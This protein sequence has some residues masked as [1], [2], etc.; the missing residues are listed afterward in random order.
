MMCDIMIAGDEAKFGQPEITL[1]TIPGCGGTQRLVRAIGKSKAMHLCLTGEMIDAEEALNSGLVAKVVP[2]E[3]LMDEAIQMGEK[4][5]SF[6]KPAAMMCK[7]AV[8]AAFEVSL[9]EGLRWERR[10]FHSTFGTN[11]QK[12]GM[13]AFAARVKNPAWTDS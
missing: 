5:A 1:G 7:E 13:E 11:D 2:K 8:N 12:I 9:S 6:S 3:D 10:L 4:I